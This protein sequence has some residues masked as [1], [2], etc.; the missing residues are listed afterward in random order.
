[1]NNFVKFCMKGESKENYELLALQLNRM[2][3]MSI[4]GCGIDEC[5]GA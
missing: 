2:N 5:P 1:M 4:E 3:G